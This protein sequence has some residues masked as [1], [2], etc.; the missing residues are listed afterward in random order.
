MTAQQHMEEAES[1][2]AEEGIYARRDSVA[3]AQ[4]HATLAV[5]AAI[6]EAID[7]AAVL[8]EAARA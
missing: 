8:A 7:V 3:R 6:I 2:L 4:V 1:S 5:A